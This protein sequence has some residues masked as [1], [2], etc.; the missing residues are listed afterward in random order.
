[1]LSIGCAMMSKPQLLL[2][3]ELSLGLMPKVIDICYEAIA[4]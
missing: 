4:G 3:D 2:I 1:M